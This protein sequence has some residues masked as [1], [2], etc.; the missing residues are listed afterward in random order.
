MCRVTARTRDR[1]GRLLAGGTT[2]IL[3]V[4][5][6]LHLAIAVRLAPITGLTLPLISYGG[7]SLVTTFAGLGL[8][9]NVGMRKSLVFAGSE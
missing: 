4:Q 2:S 3:A 1:F 5:I 9:A 7:S 6:L 8:V